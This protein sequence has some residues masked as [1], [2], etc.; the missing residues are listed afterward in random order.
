M[1]LLA[2]GDT[3]LDDAAVEVAAAVEQAVKPVKDAKPDNGDKGP[4][5]GQPET[6]IE[7]TP[8]DPIQ[9][10]TQGANG[11]GNGQNGNGN[12]Q[13][14][15]PLGSGHSRSRRRCPAW[16]S[17]RSTRSSRTSS[18]ASTVSSAAS[19]RQTP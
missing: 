7:T 13:P 11:N 14:Q 16:A 3:R 17:P 18:R 19:A 6:A 2:S 1:P 10:P 5:T 9:L 15:N 12:G 4:I 8:D